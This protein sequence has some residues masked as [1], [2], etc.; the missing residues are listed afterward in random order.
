[1]K[2]YRG[3]SL[4]SVVISA[5]RKVRGRTFARYFCGNGLMAKFCDGGFHSLVRGKSTRQIVEEHIGYVTGQPSEKLALHSPM[6]SFSSSRER[7]FVFLERSEKKR[8]K[9]VECRFE[10]ASHFLWELDVELPAPSMPGLHHI[11][12]NADPV[13][14][15][16]IVERQ[17]RLGLEAEAQD[18]DP[19][20]F[21]EALGAAIA[22]GHAAADASVHR[23]ELINALEFLGGD[24]PNADAIVLA[25]ARERAERDLEW[26]LYPKDPMDD[27][28]GPPSARFMM[29][30]HLRVSACYRLPARAGGTDPT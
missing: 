3:D 11:E 15:R 22:L 9:L 14:C 18:A 6:L 28:T 19:L 5:E 12:Y 29:N 20:R 2:L 8:L 4:P 25:N 30:K 10:E 16:E 26:L 1:M 27:G 17:L 7:A 21:M 13:H 24:R 23:A